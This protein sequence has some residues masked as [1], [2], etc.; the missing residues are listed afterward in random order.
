MP[1]NERI[2]ETSGSRIKPGGIR[3]ITM[4]E[5]ALARPLYGNGLRYNQIWLH[6]ESYL[7]LN[8]QPVDVAMSP[9]GEMWFREDTYSHDF[10]MEVDVQKKHRF[11]HEMM[12]VWQAQY[13][14][15]VRTRGLFSRFA[16]Y[17]YRLDK[18]AIRHYSLEQQA[19]LVSDYWLLQTYGFKN[20]MY[21][22][23]LRDYSPE[24]SGYSLLQRYRTAMRGFPV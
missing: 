11:M 17:S 9:N 19:S 2:N 24:E 1:V 13:G 15:F 23:T 21:L 3:L 5:I 10:S 7:P 22:H 16:D 4:G 20:Y 8:L 18:T 12:H 14:M 6:R